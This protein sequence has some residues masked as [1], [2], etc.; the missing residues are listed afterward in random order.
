MVIT[1]KLGFNGFISLNYYVNLKTK[2]VISDDPK[3]WTSIFDVFRPA[4]G[5]DVVALC[6]RQN[7]IYKLR[8]KNFF[9]N[10]FHFFTPGG[11]GYPGGRGLGPPKK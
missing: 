8:P 10:F 6:D 2:K 1:L 4:E 5:I 3:F 7:E 9:R 11:G